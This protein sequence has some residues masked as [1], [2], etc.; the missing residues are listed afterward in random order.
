MRNTNH[1]EQIAMLAL[2][3]I[4]WSLRF[5]IDHMPTIPLQLRIGIHTGMDE[6][7]NHY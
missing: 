6:R 1:A 5:K 4:D 7:V 3:F 2:E